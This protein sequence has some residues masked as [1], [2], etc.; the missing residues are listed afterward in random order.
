MMLLKILAVLFLI[1]SVTSEKFRFDNYTLYKVYPKNIGQLAVLQNLEND[2]RFD[3]WT[4]PVPSA[5]FVHIM[6]A[7]RDK[8]EFESHLTRY[9]INYE[10]SLPN[11]Q[12]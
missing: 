3:F 4:E 5:E 10:I 8:L 6:A 7:P 9:D 2:L 1:G 12:E 11:I